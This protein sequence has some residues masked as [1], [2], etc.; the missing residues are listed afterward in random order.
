MNAL[1]KNANAVVAALVAALL[2]AV[3]SPIVAFAALQTP[4]LGLPRYHLRGLAPRY[5]TATTI[6]LETG[7]AR[8]LANT[9]DMALTTEATL[10]IAGSSGAINSLDSKTLTGGSTFATN[11]GNATVT[12]TGSAFL[13][14]FGTRTLTGTIG[15]GG[16][17]STTI[18][19][20]STLFL[21]E[22]AIG[23]LI[24]SSTVGYAKVT[25]IA[26]NTSLTVV[27]NLTITNGH[28]GKVIEAPTIQVA[29][30]TAQ[31]LNAIASDTSLT[32]A[33]N[34]SATQ[35]S[36]SAKCGVEVASGWYA[37]WLLNGTSGAGGYL[38][39]QRTSV[40]AAPS[41]YALGLRRVGWIRNNSSG[42][43]AA[44]TVVGDG[45][46]RSVFWDCSA[47]DTSVTRVLS[48]GSATSWTSVDCSPGV[49]PTAQTA[50][51]N[52]YLFQ[53]SANVE[54]FW[55]TGGSGNSDTSRSAGVAVASASSTGRAMGFFPLRLSKTQTVD[56][57]LGA[58]AGS[59]AYGNVAGFFDD[60]TR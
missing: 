43:I 33:A 42:D 25:A 12:A 60:F 31:K 16:A 53:P 6:A 50:W 23:D 37:V 7:E 44:F 59:S 29:S 39:T 5:L 22:V 2:T 58:S 8:N 57:V 47:T 41:G 26:S 46:N 28:T 24:G 17:G 19:G 14:D 1:R 56:Y 48:A 27:S 45:A 11:S 40:F 10:D 18:T 34:S 32:L 35:S 30:Q 55:R 15:T 9:V 38:S 51:I 3:L 20:S 36:Q 49:P 4:A 54:M 13:T 21:T 52:A